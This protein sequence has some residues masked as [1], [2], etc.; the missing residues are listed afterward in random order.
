M[1]AL[2]VRY[3]LTAVISSPHIFRS[4]RGEMKKHQ[5]TVSINVRK[6]QLN[7]VHHL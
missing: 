2:P 4:F 5:T 7:T 6:Q 3:I 1:N